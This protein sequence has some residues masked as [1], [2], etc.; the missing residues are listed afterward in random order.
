MGVFFNSMIMNLRRIPGSKAMEQMRKEYN[1]VKD[2][3][4]PSTLITGAENTPPADILKQKRQ[5]NMAK[6][7]EAKKEKR[8]V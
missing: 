1:I 7:R 4:L 3:S 6:A 8:N 5:A 2:D